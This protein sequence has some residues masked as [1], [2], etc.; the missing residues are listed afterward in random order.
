MHNN[1]MDISILKKRALI[2]IRNYER[3]E[4]IIRSETIEHITKGFS[5]L[6]E[7]VLYES[8]HSIA[9]NNK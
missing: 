1:E 8:I 5:A 6:T 2:T 9:I 3:Y 4:R 7:N